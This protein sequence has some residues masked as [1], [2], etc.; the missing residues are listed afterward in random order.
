MARVACSRC[1][2]H[3][4]KPKYCRQH[5]AAVHKAGGEPVPVPEREESMAD[6]FVQAELDR[7]MGNP[8]DDWI[9]DMMP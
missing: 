8:V 1:G 9:A 5:I 2:K 4:G 3:F 6:I 7:A